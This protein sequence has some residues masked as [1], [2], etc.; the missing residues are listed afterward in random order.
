MPDPDAPLIELQGVGRSYRRDGASCRGGAGVTAL[1]DVSLTIHGGEFV[2]VMGPSGSGKSTLMNILGCLDKPTSGVYACR[3]R[4]VSQLDADE[5]SRLRRDTFG[6]VFQSYNLL[7][8]STARENVEL[9]AAYAGT[10]RPARTERA[11]ALLESVGLAHRLAHRPGALSGGEQQRVAI[12]RALMNGGRA[13]LADEPTGALDAENSRDIL[14]LLRGL[15]DRGHAVIVVTHDSEVA[16]WA[17]RRVD[18]LDGSLVRDT[19]A[20]AANSP[21]PLAPALLENADESSTQQ[22]APLREALRG[23]IS[24]LSRILVGTRP[25]RA[26][27][28]ALSVTVGVWSVVLMLTVVDGARQRG[29]D[30][31]SS[32]GADEISV[33]RPAQSGGARSTSARLTRGDAV[34]ISRK[35]TNV[36]EVLPSVLSQQVLQHGDARLR[37]FVAGVTHREGIARG[38]ALERGVFLDASDDTDLAPV[39]VIGSSIRDDL[40]PSHAN[41]LGRHILIGGTPFLV[42]GVLAPFAPSGA[43]MF[44]PRDRRVLIPLGTAQAVFQ[45]DGFIGSVTVLVQEPERLGET[46]RELEDLLARRHGHLAFEVRGNLRAQ[47]GFT[48]VERML[49]AL[50]AAVAAVSLLMGGAGVASTM[51]VSVANRTREIGIR[52]AVGARRRDISRQFLLESIAVTI[53]GGLLGAMLGFASGFL[54]ALLDVTVSHAPWFVPAALVAALATGILAGIVPAR[55]AAELD[56]TVAL[57]R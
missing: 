33:T 30:A 14:R 7:A 47:I 22:S 46:V 11:G 29:L 10:A 43:P 18:L 51:L 12:A 32:A 45:G 15:A 8:H 31:L 40:L 48:Q 27:L 5:L 39:A 36:R 44:D 26:I 55:R 4:D 17:E 37:S 53:T 9:P 2:A 23:K 56:P 3:G 19:P 38:W 42:K 57:A 41:P 54:L 16:A 50:T 1:H 6:F 13:V 35:A 25:F 20:S 24:S 28:T 52:M 49:S 21:S 34:A